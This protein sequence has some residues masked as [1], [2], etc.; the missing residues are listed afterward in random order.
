MLRFA[1][2][3]LTVAAQHYLDA[4]ERA[5]R[6]TIRDFSDKHNVS[7]ALNKPRGKGREIE[8]SFS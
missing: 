7:I 8:R 1:Q 2:A 6:N 4:E 3:A 5:D